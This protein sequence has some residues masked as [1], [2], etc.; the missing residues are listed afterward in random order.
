MLNNNDRPQGPITNGTQLSN[1]RTS[2]TLQRH[3]LKMVSDHAG[4]RLGMLDDTAIDALSE[5]EINFQFCG[6]EQILS[7]VF[8]Y[9]NSACNVASSTLHVYPEL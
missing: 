5:K 8:L 9:L 2:T 1:I 6:L 7:D 4:R 3:V